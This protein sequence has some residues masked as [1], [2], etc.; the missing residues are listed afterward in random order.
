[1]APT[2][3][4]GHTL[5]N[6][7]CIIHCS[8]LTE[9]VLPP[10]DQYCIKTVAPSGDHYCIGKVLHLVIIAAFRGVDNAVRH[11]ECGQ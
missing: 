8:A 11:S 3:S 7:K 4:V 10:S 5:N 6:V 2:F 9:A 1:M